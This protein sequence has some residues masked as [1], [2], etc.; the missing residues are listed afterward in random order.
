[1]KYFLKFIGSV[2]VWFAVTILGGVG[3]LYFIVNQSEPE[4]LAGFSVIVPETDFSVIARGNVDIEGGVIKV[5]AR[6][7][8]IFE[9]V[10]VSQGERVLKGQILAI[11]DAAG[12]ELEIKN[13]KIRVDAVKL[14]LEEAILNR[15]ITEREYDRVKAQRELDALPEAELDRASDTLDRAE[16]S[17]RRNQS[18]LENAEAQLASVTYSLE[19]RNVRAPVDGKVLEVYAKPG[20]GLLSIKF[21]PHFYYFPME[22]K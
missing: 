1:M 15:K 17:I 10:L 7:G 13:A 12:E 6:V 4:S 3:S 19:Q 20:V 8:G 5:S 11:Q 16:F 18:E 21:P 14:N 22:I 2:W 9:R